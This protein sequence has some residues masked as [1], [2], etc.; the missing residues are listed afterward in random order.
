MTNLEIIWVAIAMALTTATQLR[1]TFFPLGPGDFMMLAWMLFLVIKLLIL[2]GHVITPITKVMFWFWMVS[3][4]S[5]TVGVLIAESMGLTS[6]EFSHDAQA[7]TLAFVFSMIFVNSQMSKKDLEKL[8][9]VFISFTI[10]SLLII[11]LFPSSLPLITPW[12]G[13]IR[14]TGWSK[15]PNQLGLLLSII[16]FWTLYLINISKNKWTKIWYISLLIICLIMGKETD[17]DALIIGWSIGIIALIILIMEQAHLKTFLN[18]KNNRRFLVYKKIMGLCALI[19]L[20]I[21]TFVIYEKLNF[22]V[23]GVY[24]KSSQGDTRLNLWINGIA[25]IFHSPVF[26]FGPGGHS[27]IKE[28][29][30]SFE[31]HNTFIDW[32]GSSGIVGVISY[33]ALLVWLG[34]NAWRNE[35]IVMVA[36]VISLVGFSMFHYVLRQPIFWFY[37]ITIAKLSTPALKESN[38]LGNVTQGTKN[39]RR[40]LL[41]Y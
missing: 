1:L 24:N 19:I 20:V 15:N 21:L 11:I 4:T 9:K 17:S 31:A 33:I 3:L 25:A 22:V 23:A 28:P 10:I 30:L 6:S 40:R 18:K 29:F 12:Y 32:G 34:W 8:L 38:S 39:R 35:L 13:G 41:R 7:F 37:L 14:F 2:G 16:P 27:G 36:A 26:G 5:M